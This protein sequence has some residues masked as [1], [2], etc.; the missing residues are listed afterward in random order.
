MPVVSVKLNEWESITRKDNPALAERNFDRDQGSRRLAEELTA[1]NQLDVLELASG[2]ALRASSFVGRIRLGEIEVTVQPKIK[3]AP[4]LHLMRYAYGLRDLHFYGQAG[5]DTTLGSFQDLLVQQLAMEVQELMARGLHREYLSKTEELASPRGRIH[6]E[7]YVQTVPNARASL[8]CNYHSRSEDVLL[9]QILLAGVSLGARLTS[10]P[11]LRF[12]LRQVSKNMGTTISELRLDVFKLREAWHAMDRRTRAYEPSLRLIELLFGANGASLDGHVVDLSLSGFLFDMNRFF[13]T[14]VLR[15]LGEQLPGFEV[16][17]EQR[18]YGIFAYDPLKNPR[19]RKAAPPR[20]DFVI[21]K[22]KKITSVLDAKYRDLWEAALPRDMLYQLVVY[23][24][25]HSGTEQR[26]AIVYPT[27]RSD[28]REQSILVYEP[29]TGATRAR[30]DLRPLNLLRLDELLNDKGS[31]SARLEL[32]QIARNLA[33]GCPGSTSL[34][35]RS[36]SA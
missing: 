25:G 10:D 5:Y 33:F 31:K 32:Q 11:D 4:L 8:P 2:L 13:Q 19:S 3:D 17:D 35:S 20:P 15:F 28:A 1:Q 24:L 29:V 26:A 36:L 30:V 22:D 14:L 7:R 27:L 21:L 12:R 34:M 6:F 23:A 16:Q 9:N 18:L